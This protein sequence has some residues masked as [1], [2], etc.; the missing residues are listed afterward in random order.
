MEIEH[1]ICENCYYKYIKNQKF[2][3]EEEE[4]EEEDE[5]VKKNVVDLE[6]GKIY[7]SI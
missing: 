2:E 5:N 1:L 6:T 4:E 3:D 7:C